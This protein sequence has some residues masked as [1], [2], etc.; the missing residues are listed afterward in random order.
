MSETAIPSAAG[1]RAP[2]RRAAAGAAVRGRLIERAALAEAQRRAML[3]LL[4]R[5]FLGTSRNV[6]DRD[7]A[8]KDYALLLE[9]ARGEIRGFTTFAL[10]RTHWLGERLRLVCS[11]D[12]I[13]DGSARGGFALAAGWIDSVRRLREELG[14]D[15]ERW[16][17]LLICSGTR[18]YRFLPVFFRRF[19]PR[20]D[21]PT[22]S[23]ARALLDELASSVYG[24]S[25]DAETGIVRLPHPQ[26]LRPE[27]LADAAA[28]GRCEAEDPHARFFLERNPG[29]ARGDELACWTDL[30]DDNLTAAG[31]RMVRAGERKR[32]PLIRAGGP[33][34]ERP[35]ESRGS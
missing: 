21:Q 29:H 26:P 33:Y 1:T 8:A 18:T 17:W 3:A 13:V 16:L 35:G 11:G 5:H 2:S 27:L 6:F 31:L 22:P 28:N 20:H 32:L 34:D 4:Q 23:A 10:R 12:T 25:F 19:W 24:E 15:G 7:L 30:S 14:E 9:D